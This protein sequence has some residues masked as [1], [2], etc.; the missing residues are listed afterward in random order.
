MMTSFSVKKP[1]DMI[2]Y[3]ERR[4]EIFFDV[5]FIILVKYFRRPVQAGTLKKSY[6]SITVLIFRP[7]E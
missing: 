2:V 6:W 7:D 5:K 4:R 3:L 1:Q